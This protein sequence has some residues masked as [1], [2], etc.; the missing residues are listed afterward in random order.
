MT[1]LETELTALDGL[2]KAY[3]PLYTQRDGKWLL[4]GVKGYTPED[5]EKVTKAL[6]TERD[7]ASAASNALK[8][9][10][11]L[12]G[13][14]KPE[15]VQAIVDEVEEL[16]LASKG[17]LDET[18][19]EGR[20]EAR[21]K[22]KTAPLERQVT[23]AT[24]KATKAEAR[25]AAFEKAEER[26]AVRAAIQAEAVASGALPESYADGG[27]LLAVLEGALEVELET[28]A[29][30]NRK[31]GKVR[32]KDGAGYPSG[33]EVG[34]LLKQVQTR[35]GYFWG[36]TKGTGSNERPRGTN[37]GSGG[38]PWKAGNINRTEQMRILNSNP[39]QAKQMQAAAGVSA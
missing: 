32:T 35:Q 36:P 4:T 25:I 3:H 7:A 18:E 13:D 38:N 22:R 27:G 8:P 28:D 10:T 6:K 14:K 39:E 20:V 24:E 30:G 31:L 17:K 37:P 2:D 9:W 12:F 1:I 11:K 34:A 21:L 29:D 23:E 26:A 15:E 33:L 5:R 16:K 19:I